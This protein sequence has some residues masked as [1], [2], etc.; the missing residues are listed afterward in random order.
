MA[1]SWE[2][3]WD[4][5]RPE[6]PREPWWDER[7]GL[8]FDV[9]RSCATCWPRSFTNELDESK[10]EARIDAVG[11]TGVP[12]ADGRMWVPAT[13]FGR[14]DLINGGGTG[15]VDLFPRRGRGA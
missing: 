13:P 2:P 11:V 6:A 1:K 10:P 9:A 7:L 4:D 3:D 12:V 14:E 15:I 5:N 8:R